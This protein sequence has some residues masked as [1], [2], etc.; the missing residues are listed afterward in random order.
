[1]RGIKTGRWRRKGK[2][3]KW[4]DMGDWKN[5]LP[6][7]DIKIHISGINKTELVCLYSWSLHLQSEKEK[8][9]R[10]CKTHL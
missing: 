9:K 1:M 8:K 2:N 5:N 3:I 6:L 10:K 7:N 4:N